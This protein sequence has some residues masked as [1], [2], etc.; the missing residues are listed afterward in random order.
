[1]NLPELMGIDKVLRQY[2]SRWPKSE[3]VSVVLD[4][5]RDGW[6]VR[7]VAGYGLGIRMGWSFVPASVA[8]APLKDVVGAF[9][10]AGDRAYRMGWPPPLPPFRI[11]TREPKRLQAA[12]P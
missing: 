6:R 2:Q 8:D 1:V 9:I 7:L 11:G 12:K 4:N 3:A 5:D 10:E